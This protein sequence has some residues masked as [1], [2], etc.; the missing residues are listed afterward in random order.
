MK[1]LTYIKRIGLKKIF[2]KMVL[3]ITYTYMILSPLYFNYSNIHMTYTPAVE[4]LKKVWFIATLL[5]FIGNLIFSILEKRKPTFLEFLIILFPFLYLL[6]ILLGNL[7]LSI[8]TN[9]RY[10]V[11]SI[12]LS[13]HILALS[14]ILTKKNLD[15]LLKFYVITTAL[16]CILSLLV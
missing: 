15:S 4:L 13:S 12:L 3:G 14:R 11:I 8:G 6:P 10:M 5:I 7:T 9:I 16:S 1:L 2:E